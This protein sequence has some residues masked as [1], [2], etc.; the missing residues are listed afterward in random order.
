ML[1]NEFN[2][3]QQAMMEVAQHD[4]RFGGVMVDLCV[5]L[6]R[7]AGVPLPDEE[8]VE[9]SDRMADIAEDYGLGPDEM[10]ALISYSQTKLRGYAD[11]N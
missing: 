5:A 8:F 6:G 4:T 10:A 7:S 3:S 9:L 2:L 1:Y 11:G